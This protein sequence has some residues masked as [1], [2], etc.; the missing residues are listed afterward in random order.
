MPKAAMKFQHVQ[1]V[2]LS[3]TVF[4]TVLV[5]QGFGAPTPSPKPSPDASPDPGF[6]KSKAF[7]GIHVQIQFFGQRNYK[8]SY[9]K[10]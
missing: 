7:E 10:N 2:T 9:T 1:L 3:L 5:P 8:G 6:A 4:L